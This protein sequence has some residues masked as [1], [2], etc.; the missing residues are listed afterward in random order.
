MNWTPDSWRSR[1]ALQ[2][3]E[4]PDPAALERVLCELRR[5]P[6][7]VTSWEVVNLR[8][9]LAEASAGRRFVLQGGDCAER[10]FDC[11][12]A[13]IADTL[14]VLIQMSLVLVVGAQL[15]VVRIGRFA[16]Q[17]AKPRSA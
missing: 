12:P 3:P 17:Y 11:R 16:G 10:F 14:K 4:F 15:P 13:R 1:P 6:P 5:L 7:L 8:D 9:L 2:Q